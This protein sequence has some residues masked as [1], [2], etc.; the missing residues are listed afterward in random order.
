MTE[1]EGIFR[2]LRDVKLLWGSSSLSPPFLEL[3]ATRPT[4]ASNSPT[5][6]TRL[7]TRKEGREDRRMSPN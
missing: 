7:I 2:K 3:V 1:V 5:L 4:P 6:Y